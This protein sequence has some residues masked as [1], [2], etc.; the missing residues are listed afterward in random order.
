V[1]L[2]NLL[3]FMT[4]ILDKL[5]SRAWNRIVGLRKKRNTTGLLVGFAVE[6]GQ[7]SRHKVFLSHAK[8]AESIGIT[9]KTGTGKSFLILSFIL[10]DLAN[11]YGFLLIDVH[12]QLT[13]LVLHAAAALER[14]LGVD[15]SESLIIIRPADPEYSVGWNPLESIGG[16]HVF[17][18]IS[19]MTQIIKHRWNLDQFGPRTEELLRNC[20]HVLS[21]CGLTLLELPLLLSNAGFRAKCLRS[22]SNAEI[23]RYFE[24]R[25]NAASDAMQN[26][27]SGPVLNKITTFTIDPRFRDLL[28]Q[29][30]S[31]FSA[32]VVLEKNQ[33]IILD[34]SKAENGEQ[35]AF[36][37][38]L[39][40]NS[41]KNAIFARHSRK[42]FSIYGDEFQ[43]YTLSIDEFLAEIRKFNCGAV[44]AHQWLQQLPINVRAALGAIP[45]HVAFQVSASDANE[46]ASALDGGKGLAE[47]LKNLPQ[48]HLIFKSGSQPLRRLVVPDVKVERADYTDLYNRCRQRWAR[49][50][51]D[52]EADIEKRQASA[53]SSREVLDAWE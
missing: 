22:V 24:E 51:I 49:P 10:Q 3:S 48:R 29:V 16:L 23:R 33:Q 13:K 41:F 36:Y 26:A 53:K 7:V 5:L 8:R 40:L 27:L 44:V 43:N 4:L 11:R 42:L 47:E 19:E 37:A 31:T 46:I 20:L 12:G 38:S 1:A 21:M 2:L 34:I 28:G 6:D 25:Y 9:G 18:L 30:H 15:L 52:I 14:K 39:F 35:S 45:T 50:R 17:N 32:S